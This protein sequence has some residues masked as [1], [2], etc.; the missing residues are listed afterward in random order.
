VTRAAPKKAGETVPGFADLA[1]AFA[2]D[3]RV[4]SGG[5]GF[6]A[7][8][9]KSGGKIFAMVTSKGEFVV[10]LS[11]TRVDALVAAGQ[12]ERFDPGHGRRMKE[13]L[14]LTRARPN[15]RALAE[16][17]LQFVSGASRK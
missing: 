2:G 16:E 10:K 8:A 12:G 13:W 6:G 9:L 3:R 15:W 14:Q 7:N 4:A 5:A 11:K 1:A 17:A